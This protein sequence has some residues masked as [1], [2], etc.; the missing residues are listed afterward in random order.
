M[1]HKEDGA[2]SLNDNSG[3]YATDN[4]NIAGNV[5]KEAN[6]VMAQAALL[7]DS[8]RGS[9]AACLLVVSIRSYAL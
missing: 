7:N 6:G 9:H 8:R 4:A 1:V 2:A 5:L 3:R